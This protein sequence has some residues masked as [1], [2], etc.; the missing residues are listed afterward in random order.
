[1]FKCGLHVEPEGGV[2]CVSLRGVLRFSCLCVRVRAWARMRV[3][4]C[5]GTFLCQNGR[6]FC[7]RK[8]KGRVD[9]C[10]R[11]LPLQCGGLAREHG[12]VGG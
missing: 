4:R 12:R 1:M 8:L 10:L 6:V 7:G 11:A 9:L 2:F 3:V 5:H